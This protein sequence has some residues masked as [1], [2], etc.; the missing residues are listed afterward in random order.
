[1]LLLELLIKLFTHE[2]FNLHD[3]TCKNTMLWVVVWHEVDH[4]EGEI[5]KSETEAYVAY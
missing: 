1:L 3:R 5:F 2:R 4:A